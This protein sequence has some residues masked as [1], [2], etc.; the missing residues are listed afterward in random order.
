MARTLWPS[1]AEGRSRWANLPHM[2][3]ADVE[4]L[5]RK[6]KMMPDLP[7][8]TACSQVETGLPLSRRDTTLENI[9]RLPDPTF[10]LAK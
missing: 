6:R 4:C 1:R 8:E 10:S 2:V 9:R 5:E 7:F 3:A